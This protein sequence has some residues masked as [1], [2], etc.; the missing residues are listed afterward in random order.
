[1]EAGRAIYPR[2]SGSSVYKRAMIEQ[3]RSQHRRTVYVIV[4]VYRSEKKMA[5]VGDGRVSLGGGVC[6][7]KKMAVQAGATAC[8]AGDKEED[9][10]CAHTEMRHAAGFS[11]CGGC[12]VD[13]NREQWLQR[14]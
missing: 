3:C 7:V 14:R 11:S 2:L 13:D 5:F 6:A 4:G 8:V 1:M 9:G 10:G 12:G